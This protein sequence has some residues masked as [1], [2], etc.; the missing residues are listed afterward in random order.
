ME[1]DE[2]DDEVVDVVVVFVEA[3]PSSMIFHE[4][5]FVGMNLNRDGAVG[6]ALAADDAVF[7]G[8][9]SPDVNLQSK[10]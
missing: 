6:A 3:V 10:F 2:D 4:F 1:E 5:G 8:G 9:R 7:G